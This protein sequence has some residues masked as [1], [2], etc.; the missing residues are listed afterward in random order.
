MI[1]RRGFLQCTVFLPFI[2]RGKKGSDP[3]QKAVTVHHTNDYGAFSDGV[4]NDTSAVTAAMS[5]AQQNHVV[6]FDGISV[7]SQPLPAPK[8]GVV[9][10]SHGG[11]HGVRMANGGDVFATLTPGRYF[12]ER[13]TVQA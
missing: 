7:M 1:N 8:P 11:T 9:L 12:I 10:T 4:S 3:P 6:F 13:L 5:A 2:G